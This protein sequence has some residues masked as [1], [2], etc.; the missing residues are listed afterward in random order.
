MKIYK[1]LTYSLAAIALLTGCANESPFVDVKTAGQTGS[2]MTRCLA[3]KLTNTDGVEV[4]TRADVPST[5]DFKVVITRNGGS[6]STYSSTP[7]SVEYKYSEMPEV[8]TLPV[9]DYKVYAH[10]GENKPAA[11]DEPYYYGESTFG[12]DANKITDDVD[13]IVAKLANIRVTIVFH[14]S[15]ISAMSADSKVEVKVGNQGVLTFTPTESRSAYFKYV[16]NSSTLAATFTGIVDGADV[17]ET[18]T[19]DNVAPGNHYRITFRM[20]GIEDDVP[21]T[22]QAAVTVDTTVEKVDMNHTFDGEKEEYFED[23]MRPNQGGEDDPTPVEPTAPQITS[24]KPTEAGL[25]P[26]NLEAVNEVTENTYCVL[27]VVSTAENGIEAFDVIIE[28]EKLNA[29]ELS[30][31]GLSDKLD[32]VNPGSLEEPLTNLG[33]PVNVGGK[34]SVSFNI[35]GFMPLLGVLG[36]GTHN[37]ILT[38]KDANGETT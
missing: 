14:P 17:V 5:D 23:D 33:L 37:F 20:H 21:G 8:L 27:N 35:T 22:V 25:I 9:G 6:A 1:G 32:L 26:V 28:S 19:E 31:V 15:L 11:W 38:V 2:L 4:G 10:H 34:K 7:G 30:N 12:I 24:A 16:K 13:P 36:E 18:K 3:P 29:D